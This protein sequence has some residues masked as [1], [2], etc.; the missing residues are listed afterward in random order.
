MEEKRKGY[1]T[2]KNKMKLLKDILITIQIREK[3]LEYLII[4][5][6]VNYF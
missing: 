3:N 2:Q 5:P 1:K 6:L 4:N